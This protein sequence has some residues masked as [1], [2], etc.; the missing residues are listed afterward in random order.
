MARLV[1][2]GTVHLDPDGYGLLRSLLESLKPAT[3]TVEIS[4]YALEFRRTRG[5][6]LLARLDPFR[7]PDST[8]PAGLQAVSAQLEIPYEYRAAKEFADRSGAAASAVGDSEVS[9]RLLTELER[10]VMNE[11]NL[12]RLA[13]LDTPPLPVQVDNQ[14]AQVA[15][16]FREGPLVG[17]EERARMDEMEKQ[18]AG[19]VR[20]HLGAD[21]TVHVGGWEHLKGLSALLSDRQPELR[22]LNDPFP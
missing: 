18:L 5:A 8:L 12:A 22:L 17:T 9:R 2:I 1:L 21:L 4:P 10:E 19:A 14:R 15:R 7:L 3:V 20:P 11:T 16:F 13:R 6:G